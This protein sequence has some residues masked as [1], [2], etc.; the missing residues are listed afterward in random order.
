LRQNL[1]VNYN[2]N[3]WEVHYGR[4]LQDGSP[5][6]GSAYVSDD[7]W[8][9]ITLESILSVNKPFGQHHILNAVAGM[10]PRNGL[11]ALPQHVGYGLPQQHFVG[12][13]QRHFT[14]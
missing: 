7:N 9:G 13:Q 1:G 10:T 14:T 6:N 12:R 3:N 2:P 8:R 4:R 5:V 11:L